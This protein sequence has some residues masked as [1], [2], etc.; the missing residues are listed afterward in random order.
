MP[1]VQLTARFCDAAKSTDAVQTD[2]FDADTPGLALRVAKG[3]RKTWSYLF[4]SP[5]TGKRTRM[6]LGTYP[7][8]SLSAARGKALTMTSNVEDGVDVARQV[9]GTGIVTVGDLWRRFDAQHVANLRSAGDIRSRWKKHIEPSLAHIRLADLKRTDVTA[10]SSPL[11]AAGKGIMANRVF[12][13][14]RLMTRW[15]VNEGYLETNPISEMKRPVKVESVRERALSTTEIKTIFD[16]LPDASM[17]ADTEAV[18]RLLWLTGCR[19]SEIAELAV[20]EIH[21]DQRELVLPPERVKNGKMFRVPLVPGAVAILEEVLAARERRLERL[22]LQ[23]PWV[24]TTLSREGA[25]KPLVGHAVAKAVNRSQAVFKL[26]EAFTCHDIRR[27]I[28]THL[29]ETGEPPIHIAAVLN[30]L[31]VTK[32]SVTFKSYV[33]YAYEKEKRAALERWEAR[34]RG[35]IAGTDNVLPMVG[36]AG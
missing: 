34:L 22:G 14:V 20:S 6:T 11:A 21:L 26:H 9:K 16:C 31:S 10:I 4:T 19:V 13:T 3:G 27:T 24:F 5:A 17:S 8:T 23:S 29:A 33:H 15:A 1:R 28:A 36:V 2:Y 7:A 32:A 30:H 12:E 35:I 18:F 25:S